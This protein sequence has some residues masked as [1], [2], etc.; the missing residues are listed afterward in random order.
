MAR[1]LSCSQSYP[2]TH[3][4]D[5]EML[6]AASPAQRTWAV[7]PATRQHH[8]LTHLSTLIKHGMLVCRPP[9]R[10]LPAVLCHES[11]IGIEQA[12]TSLLKKTYIKTIHLLD[13]K[14][15][16]VEGEP[17]SSQFN[18][19]SPDQETSKEII[20]QHSI[21]QGDL[22]QESFDQENIGQHSIDKDSIDQE[23]IGQDSVDQDSIDQESIDQDSNDQERIGQDSVGQD[24]IDEENIGQHSIDQESIDQDSND[25]ERIGQDSVGQDSVDQDSIDQEIMERETL[26][27]RRRYGGIRLLLYPLPLKNIKSN[28]G[29]LLISLGALTGRLSSSIWSC[30]VCYGLAKGQVY[31]PRHAKHLLVLP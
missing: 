30:M 29:G 12:T 11:D 6:P 14:E 7:T 2:A 23:R 20:D 16:Q 25:Q 28:L 10:R 17:R 22:D 24:S 18:Q 13:M 3:D 15:T 21:D 8:S 31:I 5:G 1:C 4:V 19:E 27:K 9:A 26:A